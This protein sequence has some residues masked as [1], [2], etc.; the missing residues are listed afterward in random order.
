MAINEAIGKGGAII[1]GF[2]KAEAD[3]I[4]FVD[5]DGSTSPE[6]FDDLIKKIQYDGIIA[7]RWIKGAHVSPKQTLQR[8]LAS[9]TFNFIVRI[10]FR[11]GLHDTQC[12][13]KLFK[14]T[15]AK[16]VI[17]KLDITRWAFD[18]DLLYKAKKLGYQVTEVPTIWADDQNSVLNVRRASIEML[19]AITRLRLQYSPLRGMV[20]IYDKLPESLKIHKWLQR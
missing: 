1:A 7:S 11:L 13:A 3:L 4:G 15:C 10:F 8:R 18:V 20:L 17:E 5:A 2:K 9:R 12:G 14:K 16:A 6:A 19:L